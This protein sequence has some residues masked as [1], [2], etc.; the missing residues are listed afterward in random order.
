MTDVLKFGGTSVGSAERI[1]DVARLVKTREIGRPSKLRE[2][3]SR[4]DIMPRSTV[5]DCPLRTGMRRAPRSR[6]SFGESKSCAPESFYSK[7]SLLGRRM[8]S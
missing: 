5:S 2:P 6:P 1:S 7:K 3:A 4:N 8:R